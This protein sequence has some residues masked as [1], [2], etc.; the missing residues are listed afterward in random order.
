MRKSLKS[1]R[2][3]AFLPN[4]QGI[5]SQSRRTTAGLCCLQSF[6]FKGAVAVAIAIAIAVLNI[7]NSSV[8]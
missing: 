4:M 1:L 7:A 3:L 6:L 5:S 2:Q 8:S